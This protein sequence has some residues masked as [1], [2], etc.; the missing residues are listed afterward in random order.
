MEYTIDAKGKSMGR[1]A[2]E[3]AYVL[4]GKNTLTPKKNA[5]ANVKVKV[6]NAAAMSI[7]EKKRVQKVYHRH[8][9]Y[10]GSDTA[11]TL[12]ELIA[13]KGPQEALRRAVHGMLPTNTLRKKRLQ[14]L[15]I[16]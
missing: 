15:I 10:P 5:I 6:T 16:S 9:G 1:V 2:S 11:Q 12:K 4:L 3:A 14:N 7:T 8:T 13:K